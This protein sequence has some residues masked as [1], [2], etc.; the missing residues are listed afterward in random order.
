M[1]YVR[2][3]E[4][5]WPLKRFWALHCIVFLGLGPILQIPIDLKWS[6]LSQQDSTLKRNISKGIVPAFLKEYFL[7]FF[8]IASSRLVQ[9]HSSSAF[10]RTT[11]VLAYSLRLVVPLVTSFLALKTARTLAVLLLAYMGSNKF[12]VSWKKHTVTGDELKIRLT[13][14]RT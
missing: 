2:F 11:L 7:L 13:R 3:L 6:L 5:K 14:F 8:T 1:T 9:L 12:C 4:V 10:N